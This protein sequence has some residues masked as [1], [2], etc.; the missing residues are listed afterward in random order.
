MRTN[1]H[2]MIAMASML[3]M[4]ALAVGQSLELEYTVTDLGGGTYEYEFFLSPDDGWEPG[5]GWRWFIFGDEPS[6]SAGG[7][8]MTPLTDFVGDPA[9]L[10]IG[11][12]TFYTTSG[13]GHNGPTLGGVLDFWIPAAGDETL[14]W[15]GTST[16]DLEQGELLFSTLAGTEGG[17]VAANFDVATRLDGDDCR[18]DLDGDGELTIFDFLA[19]QDAFDSGDPV[20][21]FDGDGELTL[22]DFLAF[23][24]EF[25][26]GCG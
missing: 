17:A 26:V 7:T 15:K 21:D 19:F 9:S 24:D 25:D 1:T 18:V 2:K 5:F 22:F 16:A 23:Q 4:P 10:P 8:G 12:W 20:A 11:P 13:G 3:A 14:T 6:V